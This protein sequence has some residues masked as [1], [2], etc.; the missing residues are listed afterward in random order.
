MRPNITFQ[1]YACPPAYAAWYC[2]NGATCF[3]VKIGRSILYNCECAEGYMG[4]RC[5][6]KDLDGTY[7]SSS[8]RLRQAAASGLSSVH[9]AGSNVLVGV[10]IIVLGTA[11]AALVFTKRR[12][13]AKMR[14]IEEIRRQT[15]E[16]SEERS[17]GVMMTVEDDRRVSRSVNME[18]SVEDSV[19]DGVMR[20]TISYCLTVTPPQ[21][22]PNTESKV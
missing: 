7:V 6:F 19:E 13:R 5:E 11:M 20:A 16:Y 17:P 3:T 8:E 14:K 21:V 1:T 22:T 2:L 18:D 9:S 4:Q 15:L 10:I 12:H